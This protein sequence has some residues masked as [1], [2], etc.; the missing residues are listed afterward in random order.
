[1]RISRRAFSAV[2]VTGLALAGVCRLAAANGGAVS[3]R[4]E[5]LGYGPLKTDPAGFFDLPEAFSYRVLSRAGE[6][7]ADGLVVPDKFDGMGCIPLGD[8]KLALVR[9]HELKH[10]A[11]RL[12]PAGNDPARIAKLS[13]MPF[14]G[15][16]SAGSVLPGGTTTLI[17]D[18]ASGTVE[19]Q[20][21]S[22][23]GTSTNCAGGVT[24]WGSWLSCEETV[25]AAPEVEKSHGW[26]FEVPASATAA[27]VPQ[28][29]K[30]MGRFRHEAVAID[31]V[32]GIAYLTEDREDG[33]FYRFI[34]DVPG[35]L[36]VGGRLQA[37]ALGKG[38]RDTR[39]HGGAPLIAGEPI[40][41]HWIDLQDVESPRDDLRARGHA[42]GAALFARGEG[43]H[44]GVRDGRSELYFTCTS[45]G[46]M[47]LGQ[48]FRH[49]PANEPASA[50]ASAPASPPA[51]PPAS[52]GGTLELFVESSDASL[53]DYGDNLTVAPNGHLIVCEDRADGK[54]NHLRGVTPGG[55]LY[56]LARLNADTELAGACFSPDG[57]ILF[58]NAYAPGRTLAITGPWNAVSEIPV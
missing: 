25:I 43:I 44:L 11:Q 42:A 46:A 57:K 47:R 28:P 26:V 4:N 9:N 36:A 49:V 54:I 34:P 1:M 8:G 38:L 35:S 32:T 2:S 10:G 41:V 21:L 29:L 3:W 53:L 56:T 6:E 37:L 24:P 27:V 16:D 58:V 19:R 17:Y 14:Y 7:M 13:A 22:L 33:L 48:I 31:P 5:V 18:P 23:A 15:R 45:G 30:A 20:F 12:G 39:N 55:K 52:N 40:A 51:S 50:P